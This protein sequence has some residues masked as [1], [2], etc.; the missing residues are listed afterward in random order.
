MLNPTLGNFD[1]T[2]KLIL[3]CYPCLPYPEAVGSPGYPYLFEVIG[4]CDVVVTG[5][6]T[7][8]NVPPPKK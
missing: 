5:Q 3:L 1:T 4:S 8:P 6:P 7:P 2:K